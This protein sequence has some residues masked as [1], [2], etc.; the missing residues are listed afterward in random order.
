M[1]DLSKVIV[2]ERNIENTFIETLDFFYKKLVD[3]QIEILL[4]KDRTTGLNEQEKQEL[5]LLL[6]ERH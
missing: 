6:S 2:M 4:A 5:V 3:R 1:A